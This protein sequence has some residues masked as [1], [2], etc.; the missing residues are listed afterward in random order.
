MNHV[1]DLESAK[2]RI[3]IMRQFF[4]DNRKKLCEHGGLH[5]MIAIKGKYIPGNIYNLMKENFI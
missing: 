4:I 2:T 5:A 3:D 1:E